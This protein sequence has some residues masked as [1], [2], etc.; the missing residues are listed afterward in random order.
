MVD[1]VNKAL[2]I[3]YNNSRLISCGSLFQ[4]ACT[5]RSLG[6]VSLVDE[7]LDQDFVVANTAEAST[8]AFIAPGPQK[9]QVLSETQV[10][11]D[12]QLKASRL[13]KSSPGALRWCHFHRQQPLQKCGASS[14]Q[15]KPPTREFVGGCQCES[16]QWDPD[17]L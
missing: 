14:Q 15:Q 11:F 10:I 12:E 13:T 9:D 8:V 2:V 16:L 17:V 6:N 4:G 7:I 1:N 5:I 3:D